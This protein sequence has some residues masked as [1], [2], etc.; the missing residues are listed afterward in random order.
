MLVASF[1]AADWIV[2]HFAIPPITLL[3]LR[4]G[5]TALGF[6]LLAELA[7]AFS[8]RGLS[9]RNYL[10]TRDSVAAS[11]YCAALALFALM[12]LFVARRGPS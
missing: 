5:W 9:L 8:V 4:I 12:P 3:R 7:L 1:F 10:E 6:M 2:R 11:V